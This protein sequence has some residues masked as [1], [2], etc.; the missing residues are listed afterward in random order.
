MFITL[1][2]IGMKEIIK[3][4]IKVAVV[5]SSRYRKYSEVCLECFAKYF[6]YSDSEIEVNTDFFVHTHEKTCDLNFDKTKFSQNLIT[7]KNIDDIN[8]ILKPKKII[9]ETNYDCINSKLEKY[10]DNKFVIWCT[11][12]IYNNDFHRL[13]QYHSFEE[14]VKLVNNYEIENNIKY[15]L[16]FKLRPDLFL[17]IEN[18]RGVIFKHPFNWENSYLELSNKDAK[19]SIPYRLEN[20]LFV[21]DISILNGYPKICDTTFLGSSISIKKFTEN[22][23]VQILENMLKIYNLYDGKIYLRDALITPEN[24]I[25]GHIQEKNLNLMPIPFCAYSAVC[26]RSN[27]IS[28]S[29]FS[30]VCDLYNQFWQGERERL[31]NAK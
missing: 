20:T 23:T 14:G 18:N 10:R 24:I 6:N 28:G 5:V 15:D 13:Y 29:N 7:Q 1:N 31:I 19:W 21:H 8:N 26:I 16:I 12:E 9:V 3:R 22:F 30:Q 2:K 25:V 27:Y 17:D 4:K 11:N